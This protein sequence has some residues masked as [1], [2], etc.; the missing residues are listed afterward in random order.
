MG[1]KQRVV[2]VGSGNRVQEA[3]LPALHCLADTFE[4][5]TIVGRSA[6]KLTPI[7][8]AWQVPV[9][10]D[11][12][13]VDFEQVDLVFL[14]VTKHANPAVLQQL[15]DHGAGGCTLMIE[16]PVLEPSQLKHA[17]L[18]KR[19]KRV[20]VAEDTI[21]LPHWRMAKKLID[22]GKIGPLKKI[23]FHNSGYRYHAMA[24]L[25]HIVGGSCGAE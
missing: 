13:S 2:I 16:T 1:K 10:A 21:A 19:F 11:M 4:V 3:V 17:K 9:T 23:W 20:C 24:R 25:R 5:V 22:E 6:E 15:L 8:D 7:A 12:G 18:F 14:A